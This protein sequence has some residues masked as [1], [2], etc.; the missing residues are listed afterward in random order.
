LFYT[1]Y[2]L[3]GWLLFIVAAPFF[4]FYI[5][6]TGKHRQGLKQRLGFLKNIQIPKNKKIRIWLHAASVGEV[7]VARA[8]ISQ[9]HKLLPEAAIIVSTVTR[10]GYAVA[11]NQLPEDVVCIFAPLDLA[12]IV[13]RTI[14]KI[15]PDIYICL[16]TEIWP[17][18]LKQTRK[19]GA[20]LILLNGRLSESSLAG[21]S[22]IKRF[23]KEILACFSL[24]AVIHEGDAK[25]YSALG[26]APEKIRILGNAKY[27]LSAVQTD[28]QLADTYRS[29]L[30][31]H[32][33]QPVLVTGSTHT[34]EEKLLID[35]FKNIQQR[36]PDLIWVIAPRHLRRLEEIERLLSEHEI[37]HQRLSNIKEQS[38]TTDVVLVDYMGELANIYSVAR[39]VFCGGSLVERGGHNVLE[40]AI[41][42]APV[43]YGPSMKDFMDAKELL[44]SQN[45]GFP[46]TDPMDLAAKIVNF[47][48]NPQEYE[49]A[50]R[51]ALQ[52]A[53]TQVGSAEKQVALIK[54]ALALPPQ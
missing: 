31:L 42:G 43:F 50:G 33:E 46:V 36:L 21:Y 53:R 54:E 35:V 47:E 41:W 4:L 48:N 49:A 29:M 40:A 22:Q 32:Q 27:D 9:I 44:E 20:K 51:R 16:E 3:I 1:V 17:N 12:G 24:V 38:R 25:R 18:I 28:P 30:D 34:G 14:N 19:F 52:V 10:Q 15:R 45:A 7:Q 37:D 23:I 6:V 39:Y 2:Q 8:L 13:N 26:V 11:N 5:V